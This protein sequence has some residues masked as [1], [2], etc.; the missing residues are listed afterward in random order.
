MSH[1][2]IG[3][4]SLDM[5]LHEAK[6]YIKQEEN[7]DLIERAFYFAKEKHAGQYRKSGEPY[8][9]HLMHVACNHCG[10]VFT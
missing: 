2:M 8:L 1:E 7:I 4:I 3:D 6:T 9:V 10:R 5:I